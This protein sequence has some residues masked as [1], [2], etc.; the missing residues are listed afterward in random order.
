[1]VSGGLV[2]Y[3]FKESGWINKFP[4]SEGYRDKTIFHWRHDYPDAFRNDPQVLPTAADRKSHPE[5]LTSQLV[6]IPVYDLGRN[7]GVSPNDTV[8]MDSRLY[9]LEAA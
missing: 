6:L 9:G 4:L 8:F 2:R 1:M 7:D 5:N 3:K